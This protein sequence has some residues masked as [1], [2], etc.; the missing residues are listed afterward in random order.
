MYDEDQQYSVPSLQYENWKPTD[1]DTVVGPIRSLRSATSSQ[2][3][4]KMQ[5]SQP[6]SEDRILSFASILVQFAIFEGVTRKMFSCNKQSP[7][8]YVCMYIYVCVCACVRVCVCVCAD[9][10]KFRITAFNK[11]LYKC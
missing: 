9:L 10:W 8:A 6:L 7:R 1:T 11:K 4:Y 5:V 3:V 2:K